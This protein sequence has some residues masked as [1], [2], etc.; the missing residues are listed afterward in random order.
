LTIA[1]KQAKMSREEGTTVVSMVEY[2]PV[3]HEAHCKCAVPRR[4]I[5]ALQ[6]DMSA[7]LR[8]LFT[9]HAHYTSEVMVAIV[10][11]QPEARTEAVLT[12]LLRNQ[13]DI[14]DQ[15]EPIIG[16]ERS[17]H[18]T[19]LLTRHIE[20]AGQ[21]IKEASGISQNVPLQKLIE[22]LMREGDEV[23]ALLTELN[24]VMLPLEATIPMFAKHNEFVINMTK[25]LLANQYEEQVKLYDAYYNEILVLA[26][27]IR[28]AL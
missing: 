2:C 3:G 1:S 28:A 15:L 22:D 25:A 21:V 6:V 13:V 7:A 9:D 18:L 20:L 24:P 17:A 12:R 27:S 23:A 5:T 11:R 26:D 8:K 19:R 4:K 14:G 16:P 10:F